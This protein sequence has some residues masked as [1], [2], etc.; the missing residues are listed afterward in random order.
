MQLMLWGTDAVGEPITDDT[1][2][3]ENLGKRGG[4]TV[5]VRDPTLEEIY[6]PGGYLERIR[7]R[8]TE[9]EYLARASTGKGRA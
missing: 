1:S 9:Q 3:P 7:S 2:L 4:V 8:W 6:G 5:T